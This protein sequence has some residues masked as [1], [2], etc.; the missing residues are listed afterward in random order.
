MLVSEIIQSSIPVL[1]YDDTVEDA[2]ELLDQNSVSHLAV[3]NNDN[4]EGLLSLDE[5]LSAEDSDLIGSLAGKFIHISIAYNQHILSALK[6]IS[7][8]NISVLPV[9]SMNKE[10]LGVVSEKLMVQCLNNFLNTEVPGGIFVVEMTKGK[11]SVGEICRLV[12][13]NDAFVTQFNTYT[14]HISGLLIVTF[15]INK[16]EV[17]DILATLQRYDYTVRY[18]FGEELYENELKENFDNLMAYLNV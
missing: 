17:S 3:V 14:E 7:D 12:E 18:Y 10:Y 5:L 4:Y 11:F 13:T 8:C 2:I 6:L 16:T 9:L 15:K 1:H